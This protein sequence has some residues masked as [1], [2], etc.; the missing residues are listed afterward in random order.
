M[1]TLAR[2]F[3][4]FGGVKVKP[5]LDFARVSAGG[6]KRRGSTQTF[7]TS[8]NW[9]APAGTRFIFK[10]AGK[11]ANG[12]P[13]SGSHQYYDGYNTYRTAVLVYTDGSV[14][15]GVEQL[16]GSQI[17]SPVPASYREF[18]EDRGTYKIYYDYRFSYVQIDNGDYQPATT[19]ASSTAFGQ[20]FAGG[21][22]G[23]PAVPASYVNL[24]VVA[25]T[26]YPIVVPAGG[27][28]TIEY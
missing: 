20:V 23:Q 12:Q 18:S 3:P 9:T 17:G 5:R 2:N 28:I 27:Y 22:S 1:T 24:V 26:V 4:R 19:G 21:P 14:Q 7:L 10:L 6:N 25:G 11:G 13:A 16:M 8:A 15:S